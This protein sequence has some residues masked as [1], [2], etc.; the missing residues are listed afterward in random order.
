MSDKIFIKNYD[1]PPIDEKEILRY[2]GCV[3]EVE[4]PLLSLLKQTLFE[5][6]KGF[7]Y[8][9]CYR[10]LSL[11]EFYER[12]AVAKESK[13]LRT[14]LNG[15]EKVLL[16][17]A[18]VGLDIDRK[19][20][21]YGSVSPTKGALA[22]AIGAERIESLC[23]VFCQDMQTEY[24]KNGEYLT[25]RFSAGYGDFSLTAQRDIFA[26]L[27]CARRIGLTLTESLL[28]SPTKS[29]S[30]IVGI[31]KEKKISAC[32]KTCGTCEKT[33]CDYRRNG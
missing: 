1:A 13:D 16:F 31:G 20:L 6:R 2:A 3:G 26:L 5:T 15:C 25:E 29:V 24:A 30:A 12:C 8:R 18:T 27:D 11:T 7:C 32:K 10:E 9:V 22:Q 14:L 33:D 17:S 23:E 28:M 19:I 4:K 21:A